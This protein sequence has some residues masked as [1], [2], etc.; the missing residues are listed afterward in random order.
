MSTT[1]DLLRNAEE[2]A[3]SFDKGDLPLPPAKEV[4]VVACMDARLIP[5]RVLGLEEGDAHVIR[6]AGGVVTDDEI[7]SLAISQ[8]LLGTHG[9][10]PHPPHRLRD[11]H[12]HRR[13]VQALR[14]RTTPAS[15][16]SGPPRRS[17]TS[18]RTCAS[19]SPASRRAR[20]SRTR[21][22]SAASSTRSRRAACARSTP[23]P[24]SR[25]SSASP[26]RTASRAERPAQ[27]GAARRRAGRGS[28]GQQRHRQPLVAAEQHRAR[29]RVR[30]EALAHLV[31]RRV[32]RDGRG[33]GRAAARAG[34]RR[35]RTRLP[36]ETPIRV[37]P[38]SR[39]SGAGRREQLARAARIV[40]RLGRRLAA[41]C[42]SASRAR[43][44][45]SA[46][47]ARPCG[48]ARRPSRS[49]RV[50]R[51][52]R[53]TRIASSSAALRCPRAER[54]LRA[55]RAPAAPGPA[56][57][58]GSRLWA[59]A[60]R[61]RPAARPTIATSVALGQRG[62]LA[63]G[64]QP[65]GVQLPRG[66][67]PDAPQ[68]LDRQRVQ[69][70]RARSPGGHD[71]QPV[72]LGDAAR[73]LREEL[74]ARDPDRDRQPDLARAPRARSRAAISRGVPAMSLQP[75]HVEER[76]VDRQPLDERRRV[77]EDLE[78]RLARLGVGR[79]PRRHDDRVRAQ[80]PRLRAAHR[81][82]A[83]RTPSPRS[84]PRA[85]RRRR[86]SPACRAAAGRRA[87]RPTRRTSRGRRAGS[88]A[89]AGHEHMFACRADV[90]LCGHQ[91]EVASD[92]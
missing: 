30:A 81:A 49:R 35:R 60:C 79:H 80:P 9:D 44:R 10:H 39:I 65:A 19:R 70:R 91:A 66:R 67:R 89:S 16:P 32:Q 43:S 21:T 36:S 6:N 33:A 42:A 41:A 61:C 64:R 53:P 88:A 83:R 27:R 31:D 92:S 73:H 25:A 90:F 50:T 85:R 47:A 82:C 1:D 17:P 11:A 52:T 3:A 29:D 69:E 56:P 4:A 55:D 71:Q 20:S 14:S 23:G 48:T 18:T 54:A 77:L 68:P 46:A 62:D 24:R 26:P 59:S 78:D 86:R 72:G 57:R 63:D 74:R 84:S 5:T 87:A 2:Y 28:V 51:S 37:I 7:R 38:R 12:L 8:R 13:R 45:R 76:L 40:A 22:R 58:R 75:A 34:R 15:S